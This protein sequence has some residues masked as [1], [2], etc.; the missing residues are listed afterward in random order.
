[1]DKNINVTSKEFYK[2]IKNIMYET[3]Y[4]L[5]SNKKIMC[6]QPVIIKT[7]DSQNKKANISFVMTPNSVSNVTYDVLSNKSISVGQKAYL[8]HQLDNEDQGFIVSF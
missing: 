8:V 5:S 3:I 7:Y 1:M 2:V 4:E 6:M